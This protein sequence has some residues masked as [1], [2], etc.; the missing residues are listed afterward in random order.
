LYPSPYPAIELNAKE[1][2]KP[3]PK[4]PLKLLPNKERKLE[5]GKRK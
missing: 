4:S 3:K 1:E 2:Q 5:L